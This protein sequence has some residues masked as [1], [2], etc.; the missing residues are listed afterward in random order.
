MWSFALF[1]VG[2][3]ASAE[4]LPTNYSARGGTEDGSEEW[5]Y[6]PVRP[7]AS[8]FYWFYRTTHP[9]GCLNRPIVLWLQGGPGYSGSGIGNFLEFGPNNQYLEVRNSSW[10]QTANLLFV[11]SPVGV[12][13]S[14]VADAGKL[15]TNVE[16]ISDDLISMLQTF[17]REHPQFENNPL[18]IFGQ[19][20]GG[21]M[22]A[23]LTYYLHTSIKEGDITCNLKGLAIG[24]GFVSPADSMASWPDL[25]FQMSLIDD[26]QCKAIRDK[27]SRMLSESE[28]GNWAPASQEYGSLM[29]LMSQAAPGFN[30]Y[31]ITDLVKPVADW[32]LVYD[33]NIYD[34]MNGPVKEKL[35]IVP[36]AAQW[37]KISMRVPQHHIDSFD[38]GKPA[39]HMVDEI[40]KNPDVD[41]IVYSGQLDII[42]STSGAL[43]WMNRLTWEGKEE[44]DKAE[45][46]MLISPD[47]S[48]PEMFVKS[49]ENLKMYWVLNAGHVV[50]ADVPDTALRMLNRILDD[51]DWASE[52]LT[53]FSVLE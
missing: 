53:S 52:V 28:N 44:F 21:K 6:I 42:C 4:Q 32:G 18:Y 2:Y 1:S 13:F 20:Y 37:T 12:G 31:K 17:M 7:G 27:A 25:M 38:F 34:F 30:V 49:Y 50:P 29:S 3:L 48:V 22:A 9:D 26:V 40:L 10:V 15:T 36:N 46:K 8:M 19:S 33:M 5:G 43:R 23:A 11:D 14:F 16:E 45:R 41:V 47:T 24:N 39:W 35:G 51:T